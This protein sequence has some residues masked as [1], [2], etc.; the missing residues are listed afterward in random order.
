MRALSNSKSLIPMTRHSWGTLL[1]RINSTGSPGTSACTAWLPL[2]LLR[3]FVGFSGF[4]TS[5]RKGLWPCRTPQMSSLM[6]SQSSILRGER[7][8]FQARASGP[9][10]D[11]RALLTRLES[12]LPEK[13]G[14]IASIAYKFSKTLVG[15]LRDG[16]FGRKASGGTSGEV[17]V[18]MEGDGFAEDVGFEVNGVAGLAVADVGVVVGVGD[19]GDFDREA[20]KT[21]ISGDG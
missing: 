19:D 11:S 5:T 13:T 3:R 9:I 20:R 12:A 18:E 10:K 17:T 16:E 15:E 4:M 6:F 1:S 2:R 21:M 8:G 14:D 7:I